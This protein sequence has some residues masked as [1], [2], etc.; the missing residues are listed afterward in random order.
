M[1][2]ASFYIDVALTLSFAENAIVAWAAQ[3]HRNVQIDKA[4]GI[5]L[6]YL[7]ITYIRKQLMAFREHERNLAM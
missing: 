7:E 4:K 2:L 1:L 3:V 5:L 6:S